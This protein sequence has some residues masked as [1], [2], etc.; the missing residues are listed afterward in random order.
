MYTRYHLIQSLINKR[1]Y[2]RY[3][4]IGAGSG[5]IFKI[6][7]V[8]HK[9]GVDPG[10]D[11]QFISN[12]EAQRGVD[13]SHL[14]YPMTSDEF[15][16]NH[17]PNLE[18]YDIIFIDGL[19]ESHQVDKDI[20]NALKFLNEGG[21]IILHDCNP[22]DEIAQIVPRIRQTSWN[23]DVWKSIV[24]YRASNPKL[25]LISVELPNDADVSVICEGLP[26]GPS[27]SLPEELTYTW[28]DANRDSALNLFK[29]E[30]A[31]TIL[32]I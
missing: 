17:A 10:I 30:E 6:I 2:K 13:Y 29:L 22:L 28:L 11:D 5:I 32:N 21:C 8:E 18:K 15:F 20:D 25:N 16:E 24:R 31:K 12:D 1:G 7:D 19:H 9:D 26:E 27:L 14:N 4:E 3:L 23:G